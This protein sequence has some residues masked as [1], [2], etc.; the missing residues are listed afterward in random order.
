MKVFNAFDDAAPRPERRRREH[1][2]RRN[3]PPKRKENPKI[4]KRESAQVDLS[5]SEIRD[6]I[7]KHKI[8]E[9]GGKPLDEKANP[10]ESKLV[11]GGADSNNVERLKEVLRTG[12]FHFNDRTKEVLGKILKNR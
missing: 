8:K 3:L 12:A 9:N 2:A 7:M 10:E 4:I 11:K 6:K 5:P 1:R